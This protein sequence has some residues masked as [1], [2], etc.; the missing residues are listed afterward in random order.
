MFL[1]FLLLKSDTEKGKKNTSGCR[2]LTF[3][4]SPTCSL[5]IST[6]RMAFLELRGKW[7]S[8]TYFYHYYAGL[9]CASEPGPMFRTRAIRPPSIRPFSVEVFH[10]VKVYRRMLARVGALDS[11]ACMLAPRQARGCC[12]VHGT[13]VTPA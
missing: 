13:P 2:H 11:V 4:T 5:R 1:K 12:G 9:N 10:K 6:C 7:L 3:M 8:E